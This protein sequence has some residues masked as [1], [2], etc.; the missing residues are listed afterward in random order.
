MKPT[1]VEGA[2]AAMQALEVAMS[3][4]ADLGRRPW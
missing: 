3:T 4:D 2:R 1:A